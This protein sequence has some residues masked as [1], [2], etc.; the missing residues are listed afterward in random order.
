MCL[1]VYKKLMDVKQFRIIYKIYICEDLLFIFDSTMDSFK[2]LTH[3]TLSDS[4]I[5]AYSLMKMFARERKLE[6]SHRVVIKANASTS[7]C[8]YPWLSF[9]WRSR[10]FDEVW[11]EN[12]KRIKETSRIKMLVLQEKIII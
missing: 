4:T 12:L 8:V 9:P 5:Q 1:N 10:L 11:R 6:I 7:R 3:V 2:K